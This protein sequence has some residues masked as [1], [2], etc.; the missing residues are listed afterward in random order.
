MT[1]VWWNSNAKE[2]SH[3]RSIRRARLASHV[4]RMLRAMLVVGRLRPAQKPA[5]SLQDLRLL[6]RPASQRLRGRYLPRKLHNQRGAPAHRAPRGRHGRFH[7]VLP[8]DAK[9]MFLMKRLFPSILL[10]LFR[11]GEK[12]QG[13][14]RNQLRRKYAS[15]KRRGKVDHQYLDE[16]FRKN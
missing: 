5:D 13:A 1:R 2:P 12:H 4:P 6:V 11:L 8:A 10:R 9:F 3:T 7:I 14:F 16:V 15:A